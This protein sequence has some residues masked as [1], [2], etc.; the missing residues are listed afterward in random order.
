MPYITINR[1]NLFHNLDIISKQ[2]KS[3]DRVAVVLK[4]N[5][6]GHGLLEISNLLKEYGITKCVVQTDSEALKV[7]NIFDY[8]LVLADKPKTYNKNI[9]YTINSLDSIKTFPKGTKVEL[10]VDS[11]MHRNG[12]DKD[13]LYKA[14]ELISKHQLDLK[15]VF[16][17]HRSADELNSQW[18]WQNRNFQTIKNNSKKFAKEFGFNELKFHSANSASLFRHNDF[19]ED[20]ARVGIATYGC[21]DMPKELFENNLKPVLSVYAK[22]ISSRVLKKGEHIG[23]GATFYAK[24]DLRVSNYDFGYGD[25][26]LRVLSNNFVTPDGYR[27]IGRISMDNSSF[28]AD[29][30]EILIFNNA[31]DVAKKAGTIS[32]EILTSLKSNIKRVIC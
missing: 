5:A 12:I 14:F 1:S 32:Y 24:E 4:D 16:T 17:H 3:K 15:A 6:Y 19:N 13:E 7:K 22:K 10:K 9:H 20:L 25:G 21:L 29:D 28:I 11:G 18:F 8:I 26:F 31:S 23:Y 27:V 2:A 30:D